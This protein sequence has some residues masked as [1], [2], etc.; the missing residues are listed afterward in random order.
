MEYIIYKI[1]IGDKCYVGSTKNF[2][3]RK[4][5]HKQASNKNHNI[6]LYNI[7]NEN[8]GWDKCE[9]VPIEKIN[10]Q[11][12]IDARIREQ[13]WKTLLNAELNTRDCHIKDKKEYMRK[14]MKTYVEDNKE[15]LK[16][17]WKNNYEM[18]KDKKTTQVLKNYYYKKEVKRL[19]AINI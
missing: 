18:N 9:C 2:I 12:A 13:Y 6:K 5:Q 1:V 16:E 4:S 17:V 10:C 15:H 3:L 7:I 14:Y 19:L 11:N 8:G